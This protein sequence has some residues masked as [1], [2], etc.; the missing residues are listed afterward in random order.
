MTTAQ[1]VIY[2]IIGVILLI[3]IPYIH[4][5]KN[6]ENEMPVFLIWFTAF[7]LL[8]IAIANTGVFIKPESKNPCPQLEEVHGVY[9]I[10][11]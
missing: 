7:F 8:T 5:R 1:I 4:Y 11:K 3:G 2:S 6:K 9:K 10:L